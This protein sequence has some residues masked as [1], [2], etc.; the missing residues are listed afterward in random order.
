MLRLGTFFLEARVQ[1]FA[2][3]AQGHFDQRIVEIACI[4]ETGVAFDHLGAGAAFEHNQ[5]PRMT[6]P[7]SFRADG[8]MQYLNRRP[9]DYIPVDADQRPV[10]HQRAV[11]RGKHVT[12]LCNSIEMSA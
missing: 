4:T 1:Q 12:M 7:G 5:V 2:V 10:R 6:D 8:G 9:G 3:G 11:Q